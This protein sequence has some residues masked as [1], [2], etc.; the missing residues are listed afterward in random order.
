MFNEDSKRLICRLKRNCVFSRS[1]SF[2][3]EFLIVKVVQEDAVLVIFCLPHL[4]HQDDCVWMHIVFAYN[5]FWVLRMNAKLDS[6]FME[7]NG[8]SLM[9]G[10]CMKSTMKR[11]FTYPKGFVF[12]F[13]FYSFRCRVANIVHLIMDTLLMMRYSTKSHSQIAGYT[14]EASMD[15]SIDSP[16]QY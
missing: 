1:K 11:M 15:L 6:M 13:S 3:G 4:L 10:N 7:Y 8:V 16:I 12:N 14:I 5:F 2:S 9:S